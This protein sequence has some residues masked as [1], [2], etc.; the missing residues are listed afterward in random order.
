[1]SRF[2][3]Q[4][5]AAGRLS[6]TAL[7]ERAA[8]VPG[9][10]HRYGDNADKCPH[11]SRTN[12]P[13]QDAV[14]RKILEM[15]K[16]RLERWDAFLTF[17][18]KTM[19]RNNNK[20]R[21]LRQALLGILLDARYA[22]LEQLASLSAQTQD[23]VPRLFARTWEQLKTTVIQHDRGIRQRS[24]ERENF[25]SAVDGLAALARQPQQTGFEVSD[26]GMRS[27]ARTLEPAGTGDPV[28][29]DTAVD[30][31]LRSTA[32]LWRSAAAAA[33]RHGNLF[34]A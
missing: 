10:F 30:P 26:D 13:L 23:P 9:K 17:V 22:V 32:R 12:S 33:D 25:V 31:E 11:A 27:L 19:A 21:P 5:A 29:Y 20:N 16:R 2:L 7:A 14:A 8:A 34:R 6:E 3:P 18:I 24:R 15:R 1:M 4:Q 28:R